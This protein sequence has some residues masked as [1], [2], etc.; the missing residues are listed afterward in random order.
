MKLKNIILTLNFFSLMLFNAVVFAQDSSFN[1]IQKELPQQQRNLL[2]QEKEVMISNREAFKTSLT[3][4]QLAILND[5][6]I[7]KNEIRRRLVATFS[8][9]QKDMVKNQQISLR[10][11]RDN[12]RKTLT[13][14]QRK[15]LKERIDKIRNTKDRGELKDGP[16]VNNVNNGK[17]KR[18]NGN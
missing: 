9:S 16:R 8:I 2:Q 6:T 7:S 12:F 11:T 3:S 15:M 13:G 10:K 17:K 18:N 1:L 14:E 5:K 4:E